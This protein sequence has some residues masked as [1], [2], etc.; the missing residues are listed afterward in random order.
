[1]ARSCQ[2]IEQHGHHVPCALI[3]TSRNLAAYNYVS[4]SLEYELV[5]TN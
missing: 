4:S 3:G 1:M 2:L 5:D